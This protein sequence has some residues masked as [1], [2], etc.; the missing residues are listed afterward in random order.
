ML[1]RL[2]PVHW[3]FS[4]PLHHPE[5]LPTWTP[6]LLGLAI[7]LLGLGVLVGVPPLWLA[8]VLWLGGTL[9]PLPGSIALS[10]LT[11]LASVELLPRENEL[12]RSLIGLGLIALLSPLARQRF[13]RQ[14]WKW[15]TQATLAAL[16]QSEIAT[17][18]EQSIAHALSCLKEMACADG[19]IVLRQ[20]DEVTAEALVCLPDT[21]LP[22]RLTT[23][24]LFAEAIAQNRCLYYSNYPTVANAAPILLGQGVQ[25]LVVLPLQQ[26]E[27]GQGAILLLWYRPVTFSAELQQFLSSLLSGLSNLLRFQ[28]VTLRLD[29]LQ[30]RFS[31]MLETIPQGIVFVDESG[32]QGWVNHVAAEQLGLPQG[33]VQPLAISQAMATLRMQANNQTEIAAQAAQFFSQPYAEIHDWQWFFSQPQLKVLSLSSKPIYVRNV[34]GRLWVLD[35]ITDRQQAEAAMQKAREMAEAAA[36]AKSEFLA[37]VSHE[38]RTPLNGILGYT[39]IL[40]KDRTLSEQQKNGL[41]IISRC[42]EHLLTLINDILDLSKIEARRMELY[43]ETFHFAS[44]LAEIADICRIRAEQ[45]GISLIYEILPPLPQYVRADEKRLRQVLLNILGNAVKFTEQGGVMF[46]VGLVSHESPQG[47][48]EQAVCNSKVRFQIEDTGIGIAA[49]QLEAIFAPFQRVGEYIRKTEGTGLGLSISRQLVQMMGGEI[50]VKSKLGE[51]SLF[52]FELVLPEMGGLAAEVKPDHGRIIGYQGK[53]RTILVVDDK[54][55]NR[56][57]LVHL[58]TPLGFDV[59]EAEDG[60]AG[61]NKASQIRPDVVLMDLVMPVM[62]GFEATRQLRASPDLQNVVVIAASASVFGFDQQ[63]SQE[64]GCDGFV[65]KPIREAELL[66]KLQTCLQLEWVY[67]QD[68]HRDEDRQMEQEAVH[69]FAPSSSRAQA[70]IAIPASEA[71]NTLLD[72]ALMGDLKGIVEQV[73]KLEAQE[74]QWNAFAI[75][76]RQL[77]K[78][79]K[80]KQI[81]ELIQHYQMQK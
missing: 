59:V 7:A 28:D 33:A 18:A 40:E 32:E 79:F 63:A 29:K 26:A 19:A 30:A 25:S 11:L 5:R 76:I 61:L 67:E 47:T 57:V 72:L 70:A 65:S 56:S 20:L 39:Q 73:A 35:D 3:R 43:P 68:T 17:S 36:H 55:A 51:G 78:G 81:L 37:N 71:L 38:I 27:N 23:P 69:S 22:S 14:E 53:R 62:D 24:T 12:W 80:E 4:L 54:W 49:E 50:Q 2:I 64:A 75:Q 13:L 9:L 16:T 58:L 34:P 15:A 44:F 45:K 41:G 52:W 60:Q 66:A 8:A 42:G 6:L 48:D 21:V 77:A 10:G 1:H 74:P 46:K 31:A